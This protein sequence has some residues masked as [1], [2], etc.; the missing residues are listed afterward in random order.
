M[1]ALCPAF[2]SLRLLLAVRCN[3]RFTS[4][5]FLCCDLIL[6]SKFFDNG[7]PNNCNW[8]YEVENTGLEPVA[9]AVRSQRSTN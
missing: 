1:L 4:A 8:L 3:F 2:L 6:A 5:V 9:S 7:M